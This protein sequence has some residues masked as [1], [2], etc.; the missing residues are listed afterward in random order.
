[1]AELG[2]GWMAFAIIIF[3][4]VNTNALNIYTSSMGL[5]NLVNNKLRSRSALTIVAIAQFALC[6]TPL[7][8]PS[9]LD[10]FIA[11]LT[12]SGGLFAPFWTLVLID[13][14][15]IRRGR[16]DDEIFNTAAG[17]AHWHK[18]GFNMAGII[19]L[20]L[21]AAVFYSLSYGA[22][23][24]AEAISATIPSIIVTSVAYIVLVRL[25]VTA[26]QP[27]KADG[28]NTNISA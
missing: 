19:S 21:G 25:G 26:I 15:L 1:M 16:L 22:K 10:F 7:L 17:T 20:I 27:A 18:N 28:T 24:V 12:A 9:F 6:F 3:C 8:F 23:G 4:T 5:V 11:F 14:F 13:Y 2:L